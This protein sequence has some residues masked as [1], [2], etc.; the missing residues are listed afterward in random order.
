MLNKS[1]R[2]ELI[3]KLENLEIKTGFIKIY[4]LEYSSKTQVIGNK[5]KNIDDYNA[6]II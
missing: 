4:K 3:E 6:F 1:G 5:K 2:K